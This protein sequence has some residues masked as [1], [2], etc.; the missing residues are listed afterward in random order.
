MVAAIIFRKEP[1]FQGSD[2]FDQLNKISKV[3]GTEDL[4]KYLETYD[5]ELDKQFD[6]VLSPHT[7]KPWSAFISDKTPLAS[8]DAVDLVDKFLIYDHAKR[9]LPKEAMAHPF[10][11]PLRA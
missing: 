11:Q 9:M 1:F 5:L 3:L 10:F 4:Y 7:R 8:K 6:D 2:N